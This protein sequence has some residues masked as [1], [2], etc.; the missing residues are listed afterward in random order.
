MPAAKQE[1]PRVIIGDDDP[2]ALRTLANLVKLNYNIV[3]TFVSIHDGINKLPPYVEKNQSPADVAFL[4]GSLVNNAG[5][6]GQALVKTLGNLGVAFYCFT[7]AELKPGWVDADHF[8]SRKTRPNPV[9]E[10]LRS[11]NKK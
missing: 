11:F 9:L 7:A 3:M 4:D 2:D 1:G 8:L 5:Q 6:E 10:T